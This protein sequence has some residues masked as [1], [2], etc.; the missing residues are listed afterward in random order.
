MDAS[1]HYSRFHDHSGER[2]LNSISLVEEPLI[3]C[4]KVLVDSIHA[5]NYPAES[6]VPAVRKDPPGAAK[7]NKFQEVK[8]R[9]YARS[10]RIQAARYQF[11]AKELLCNLRSI[12]NMKE[13][14]KY[15]HQSVCL[16]PKFIFLKAIKNK[17]F[18]TFGGLLYE[19]ISK[20]LPS[21]TMTDKGHMI[22]QRSG[23]GSTGKIVKKLLTYDKP[24]M[25]CICCSNY[26]RRSKTKYSAWLH[27]VT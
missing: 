16:L 3:D 23:V 5:H 6:D 14:T 1:A 4:R 12:T 25:T 15:H 11:S 26:A 2:S 8:L 10:S 24:L 21:S 22:K 20:H 27:L 7:T 18:R 13:L 19:L 17:Q 9:S